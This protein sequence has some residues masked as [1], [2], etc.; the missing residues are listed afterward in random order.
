MAETK[1]EEAQAEFD[2]TEKEAEEL[3]QELTMDIAGELAD[4]MMKNPNFI[5]GVPQQLANES[6]IMSLELE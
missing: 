5:D 2:L 6:A 3:K 1:Q 4:E